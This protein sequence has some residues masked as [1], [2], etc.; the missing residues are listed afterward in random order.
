M[1]NCAT[2]MPVTCLGSV[3]L[4]KAVCNCGDDLQVLLKDLDLLGLG[5]QQASVFSTVEAT[6][7][8]LTL[9]ENPAG[10]GRFTGSIQTTTGTAGGDG[11]VGVAHGATIT[12]RYVDASACGT[13][14]VTVD[15]TVATDCAGPVI[16]GVTVTTT[17][18]SATVTWTTGEPANSRVT[19]GTAV[20]PGTP[21]EDL[22]NFVTGHSITITGLTSCT[23]YHFSVTSTD[24]AGNPATSDNGGAFHSFRTKGLSYLLGPESFESGNGGWTPVT[25]QGSPW[26]RTTCRNHSG[27]YAFKVGAEEC[28]GDYLAN[29]NSSLASPGIDL[30]PSGHG[31]HLRFWEWGRTEV[32]GYGT[33][34]DKC[35]VQVSTD[36]GTSFGDIVPAYGGD[37]QGWQFTDVDLAAYTGA[38]VLRF[39][40]EADYDWNY[41][42]WYVDEV[43]VSRLI[44]CNPDPRY[45]SKTVQDS[46]SGGG[47]GSGNG[48]LDAGEDAVLSVTLYNQ[49]PT[50]ATGVTGT[51][52]T[53]APDVTVTGATAA[54]QDIP[55][56]GT[57]ASNAPHFSFFAGAS[58]ACG[59]VISFNLHVA[60]NE[61]PAGWDVPVTVATGAQSPGAPVTVLTQ[62]FNGFAGGWP[63]GWA[64]N[65]ASGSNNYWRIPTYQVY[66]CS[67]TSDYNMTVDPSSS[68]SASAWSFTPG[69]PLASGTTYTLTFKQRTGGCSTFGD[70]G[71]SLDVRVGATQ[72]TDPGTLL[73]TWSGLTNTDCQT[74][75][76]TFTVPATGTYYLKFKFVRSA[77]SSYCGI[78]VDDVLVTYQPVACTQTPCTPA[79][80]PE[81]AGTPEAALR[82]SGAGKSA[83]SWGANAQATSYRL[84]RGTQA[85]LP[86]LANSNTDS[87]LRA[88][89]T[90]PT[91]GELLAETPEG[92]T[93]LW[94]LVTGV[95]GAGEGTAGSGASG[96]RVLDSEGGCG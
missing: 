31:Y 30:G 4:D 91:T 80:P 95:N 93:F 29:T 84:Y 34:R 61:V 43:E 20:P 55:S 45:D 32:D 41:E 79:A 33:L 39:W 35:H 63:T 40:F 36:G 19:W 87:C 51:L 10:S 76:V 37:S 59:T 48:A 96:Q 75:T 26:I 1:S 2:V 9:S 25:I 57:G 53:T 85:Q 54:F 89:P 15:K 6:P 86:N 18:V 3:T 69:L 13:P 46:C 12:V 56:M 81:T 50:A 21:A 92:G 94:F 8:T 7:E 78:N 44:T 71:S 64:R 38:V 83:L 22:A 73:Q 65:P 62:D 17:D 66:N 72:D 47:A 74:R 28:D 14:N 52:S 23:T 42:G 60:S 67:S 27:S 49:G 82:W 11:K 70:S 16:T 5:T 77:P 68:V 90:D 58:V 88:S 24:G